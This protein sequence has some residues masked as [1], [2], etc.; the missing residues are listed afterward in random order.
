MALTQI[1]RAGISAN[2]RDRVS[3][4]DYIPVAQ[5]A[6]IRAGTSTYDATSAIQSALTDSAPNPDEAR[7]VFFPA[8]KYLCESGLTL[9]TG[10]KLIGEALEKSEHFV[11]KGTGTVIQF[12]SGGITAVQKNKIEFYNIT[13]RTESDYTGQYVVKFNAVYACRFHNVVISHQGTHASATALYMD[14]DD[15]DYNTADY[16]W[17]NFF[18]NCLFSTPR[19][20]ATS[21]GGHTIEFKGSDSWF[22]G[23]YSSGGKGILTSAGG[24]NWSN[25]HSE[26]SHSGATKSATG[27][28]AGFTVKVDSYTNNTDKI[29]NVSNLYCDLNDIAVKWDITGTGTLHTRFNFSNVLCR[30]NARHDFLFASSGSSTPN[31]FGG[32]IINYQTMGSPTTTIGT[33]GTVAKPFIQTEGS[34]ITNKK[35]GLETDS[36][37]VLLDVGGSSTTGL[38]GLTNST[39]YAGFANNTNFGGVV[40]GAG[41]NGNTPFVAASKLS[42]GNALPLTFFTNGTKRLSI[43]ASTGHINVEDGNI[44]FA[45]GHGLDF[46]ANPNASGVAS[47]LF[48]DYEE[49]SFTPTVNAGVSAISYSTQAGRYTKIGDTVHFTFTIRINSATLTS[50]AIKFAGLP[51]TSVNDA[52]K[53]GGAFIHQSSGNFGTTSTF[54]VMGNTNQIRVATAAGDAMAGTATSFNTTN[55]FIS[56]TGFYHVTD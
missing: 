13:L 36:P 48:H 12:G 56:L 5:H 10:A 3:V 42:N 23:I 6:A 26:H 49:G 11:H 14:A 16:A 29:I 38:S 53:A 4:L 44:E 43:D 19:G 35:I 45:S 8:G 27:T 24:N 22:N 50:A 40:L 46:S 31:T 20:T 28:N 21:S 32:S 33:S 34:S 15:G 7:A 30:S 39:F 55:R 47:N 1:R 17:S 37:N 54:R 9:E 18:D 52:D 2:A 51:F 25:I 41:P